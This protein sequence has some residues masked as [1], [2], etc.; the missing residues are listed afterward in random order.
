MSNPALLLNL[1]YDIVMIGL[2]SYGAYTIIRELVETEHIFS[3]RQILSVLLKRWY[4][5]LALATAFILFF[6]QL[7]IGLGR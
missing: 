5:A 7:F 2:G 3:I 1:A 6:Y 4:A